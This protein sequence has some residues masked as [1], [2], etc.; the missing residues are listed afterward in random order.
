M[1]YE[2]L[3]TRHETY[4]NR[5]SLNGRSRLITGNRKEILQ[6]LY[7][8]PAS[9]ISKISR[10]VKLTP[11][12]VKWHINAL[13]RNEY[14]VEDRIEN[15]SIFYPSNFLDPTEVQ[16]LTILNDET[17]GRIFSHVFTN[18]GRTQKQIKQDL[19][20]TQNTAGYF[21]RKLTHIGAIEE[22]HR[23]KFKYYYPSK[24]FVT[25]FEERDRKSMEYVNFLISRFKADGL[26]VADLAAEGETLKFKIKLK[27][28][29]EEII[30]QIN[31]FHSLISFNS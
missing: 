19:G 30:I 23:G 22:I 17:C 27:K 21:L 18:P 14:I 25:K 5:Y 12:T 29:E 26:E 1:R 8:Y 2:G 11:N 9:N 7:R 15:R 24:L 13:K 20:L 10:T 16:L 28:S 3:T 6:A 4:R 31:P